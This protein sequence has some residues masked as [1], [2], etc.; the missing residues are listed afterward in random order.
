MRRPLDPAFQPPAPMAPVA[1]RAPGGIDEAQLDGK[2]DTG[3][4]LC[5]VPERLVAELDLPPVRVVRAAGFGGGLQ[6]ATVY[7]I[8]VTLDG[9]TFPRVEALV[10]RRPYAIIGRNVL[11]HFVVRVDGPRGV[12]ELRRPRSA[13]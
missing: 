8:D 2:I 7:R 3:A 10:T 6:E 5:A 4:D 13:P 12:L 11:R 1:V 9:H